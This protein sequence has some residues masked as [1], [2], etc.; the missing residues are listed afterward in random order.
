M[1]RDTTTLLNEMLRL[2][3]PELIELLGAVIS[4]RPDVMSG[5]PVFEGTRVLVR[6][7][8]EYLQADGSIDDFL[9]GFPSVSRE[10]VNVLLKVKPDEWSPEFLSVLGGLTEEIER[11]PQTPITGR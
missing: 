2:P 5:A 10:Q 3:D 8:F 1:T 7:F 11:P 9:D 4:A 6:T